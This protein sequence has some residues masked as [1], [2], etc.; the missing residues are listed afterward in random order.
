MI[1][2]HTDFSDVYRELDRLDHVPA[3]VILRLEAIL[4]SQFASSQ[5][6]VHIITGSLK[7]SGDMSS[8]FKD[9]VWEGNIVYGG[10]SPGFPNDP[11]KYAEYEQARNFP[12]DFMAVAI[13]M[14]ERYRKVVVEH[15]KGKKT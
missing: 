7:N 3:S 5:S 13:S 10:L 2:I 15:V 1:E 14:D 9:E 8:E 12:H 11:V 4:A 6:E